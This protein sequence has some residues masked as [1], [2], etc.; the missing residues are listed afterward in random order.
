MNKTLLDLLQTKQRHL[1]LLQNQT[2]KAKIVYTKWNAFSRTDVIK[3]E[4][5]NDEM[6]VTI[7]GTANAPM[8]RFDGKK[9]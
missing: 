7:D 9:K 3:V 1:A 5:D 8:Y 2:K 6:I 4:G